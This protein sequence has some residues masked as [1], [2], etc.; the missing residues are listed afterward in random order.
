MKYK[1]EEYLREKYE[2]DKL[3]TVKIAQKFG[4]SP[5]TIKYYLNKFGVSLRS[6]SDAKRIDG[7]EFVGDEEVL[8]GSLLGDG[9]LVKRNKNGLAS[10]GKANIGYDHVFYCGQAIL[11]V[12]PT[13]RIVEIQPSL[14]EST[15]R[16]DKVHFR[17]TTKTC[18]KLTKEYYRWYVE[19]PEKFKIIPKDL[20]L[21]PKIVLHWFMDDGCCSW[22]D[23][24]KTRVEVG[25]STQSFCVDDCELLRLKL[26]EIGLQSTLHK[27]SGGFERTVHLR[28]S[29]ILDFFD[30]IG[31]CPVPSMEYKWKLKK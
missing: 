8:Y 12:N 23:K 14:C 4:V 27:H 22:R 6:I 15:Y 30:Y 28:A 20:K 3:S 7:Y 19:Y 5:R 10:F 9:W 24:Q 2:I 1:D 17:F 21:T 11:S 26:R 25:F 18:K 13:N 31:Q 16:T 29:S